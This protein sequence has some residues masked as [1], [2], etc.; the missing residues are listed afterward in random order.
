MIIYLLLT[1]LIIIFLVVL[2]F[3]KDFFSPSAMICESYIL[4]VLCAIYNIDYWKI[5]LSKRTM[6]VIIVGIISFV[7]T[8]F[9][10][11]HTK[12]ENKEKKIDN[13]CSNN[14]VYKTNK[15][16]FNFLVIIQIFTAILYLHYVSKVAGGLKSFFS[17]NEMMNTYRESTYNDVN[18]LG[19]PSYVKQLVNISK[20]TASIAAF[21]IISSSI[22][23]KKEKEKKKYDLVNIISIIAYTIT[24]LL[25]GGRYGMII[26]FLG[27]LIM[28]N[29]L[30]DLAFKKNKKIEIVKV[31][32]ISLIIIILMVSFSKL[33]YYVGRTNDSNFMSYV[34]TYFGG[35]I[36]NIDLYLKNNPRK[37][38]IVFGQ[39]TFSTIHR[40]LYQLGVENDYQPHSEFMR[41]INGKSTGNVYTGFRNYYSDF[42]LLGIIIL[43]AIQ[44]A[45]WTIFYKKI[46]N[47]NNYETID[48]S[49]LVYC[50]FV[51][52]TLL[53]SYGDYF[54]GQFISIGTILFI[55]YGILIK[56]ICFIDISNRTKSGEYI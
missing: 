10:I 49:L 3:D 33:R 24:C 47:K 52:G 20:V 26:F 44:S 55:V 7:F 40:Y 28:W 54:Y 50:I 35:S 18:L 15:L 13:N 45:F 31:F 19:I 11:L 51:S 9:I 39:R 34:T 42:G 29:I 14:L 48:I 17:F 32:K 43:S 30:S 41:S 38:S 25:S 53:H 5:N 6:F 12:M 21:N 1:A 27:M 36:E 37:T 2:H 22:K 8:S 23:R 4:A 56:K 16:I 46:R